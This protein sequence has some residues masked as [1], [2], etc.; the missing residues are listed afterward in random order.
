MLVELNAV[1]QR[2]KAVL[3]G[4]DGASVTDV[5][6]RYEV[7]RQSVHN[8][9]RRHAADGFKG[10]VDQPVA[11]VVV[12]ASDATGGGSDGCGVASC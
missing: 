1:E 5:A 2:L 11:A 7:T 8:W 4:L 10:L 3:E 12:S 6:R 9:L